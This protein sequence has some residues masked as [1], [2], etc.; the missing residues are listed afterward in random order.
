M[1]IAKV[2][3]PKPYNNFP[4]RIYFRRVNTNKSVAERR[5]ALSNTGLRRNHGWKTL[6]YE[7]SDPQSTCPFAS[8]KGTIA[9]RWVLRRADAVKTPL[10]EFS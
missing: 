10:G 9:R 4:V 3:T 6:P 1:K 2:R 8:S 7:S 5:E